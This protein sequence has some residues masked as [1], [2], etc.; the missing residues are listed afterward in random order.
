MPVSHGASQNIENFISETKKRPSQDQLL[1]VT[2]RPYLLDSLVAYKFGT[3]NGS[4]CWGYRAPDGQQY[5]FMGIHIGIIVVNATTL[6]IVDTVTGSGCLWQDLKTYGHY[7]FGVSECGSG[8]RVIDLQYL[9][10]SVHLVSILPTSNLG[11]MSSHNI[12]VDT[13]E[14]YLYAE[15]IAG[16]GNN[17]FIHDLANPAAPIFIKAFGFY[18]GEIHDV[19]A[20]DDTAYVAEGNAHSLSV[21]DVTDKQN[22]RRIGYV[23]IPNSGYV[24]NVWP[25]GD[26]K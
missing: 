21:F 14:G 6:Q 26:R 8:L 15:G 18:A 10:D 22:P 12:S 17:I 9:P 13:I 20:M 4:D 11:T 7:L 1:P 24:H 2:E 5:A 19:W 25:T 23:S 3:D 16:F